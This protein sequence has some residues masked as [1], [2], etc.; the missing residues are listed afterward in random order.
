M[1]FILPNPSAD[2]KDAL[3]LTEEMDQINAVFNDSKTTALTL[4]KLFV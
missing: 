4:E 2:N 3:L 1:H